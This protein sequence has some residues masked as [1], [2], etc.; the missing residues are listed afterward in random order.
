MLS[1]FL[2][3]CTLGLAKP[4]AAFDCTSV[5]NVQACSYS[6]A[7]WGWP[8]Q[9]RLL[10]AQACQTFKRFYSRARWGWP[11]QGRLLIAQ[12]RQTFKRVPTHMHVRVGQAACKHA[13]LWCRFVREAVLLCGHNSCD[14][15]QECVCVYVLV[16][17]CV[18]AC[19]CMYVCVYVIVCVCENVCVSVCECVWMCTC[20]CECAVKNLH[21]RVCVRFVFSWMCLHVFVSVFAFVYV[22]CVFVCV[23]WMFGLF[24]YEGSAPFWQGW[25]LELTPEASIPRNTGSK[26]LTT[27]CARTW[28]HMYMNAYAHERICTWT[29]MSINAYAHER[30][31]TWTHMHMNAHVHIYM[32]IYAHECICTW[33]RTY[34]NAYALE[35]ICAYV[36]E[37]ICTWMHMHMNAYVHEN[38]CTWMHMYIC[39]WTHMYMNAYV[40]MYMN[41]DVPWR[42]RPLDLSAA[43][44]SELQS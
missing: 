35:R 4:G 6:R 17:V 30:I 37:Y 7:R 13:K 2:L 28:T 20:A 36:H 9:G 31:R 5:P 27:H 40:H 19:V 25:L 38:I 22:V 41:K 8:S 39:T 18:R 11:S 3:T 29:H 43:W 42:P 14:G 16:C 23:V 34:I 33:T 10:I 12:T 15:L 26:R 21:V 32:N 24:C 1:V 44:P